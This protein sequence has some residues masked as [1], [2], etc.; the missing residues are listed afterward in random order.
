MNNRSY[1]CDMRRKVDR[2]QIIEKGLELMYSNGYE[3]TGIKEIADASGI[4]KGSFYNYFASKE[5][6]AKALIER[7]SEQNY[8]FA[9]SFLCDQS[10]SPVKRMELLFDAI[11]KS[12]ATDCGYSKGCFLGN[13]SQ[14]IGD[15]NPYLSKVVNQSM[16]SIKRLYVDCLKEAQSVGEIDKDQDPEMLAEFIINSWQGVLLRAKSAKNDD[17]FVSFKGQVFNRLLK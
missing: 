10:I 9:Q 16:S 4:L 11:W 15:S 1:I 7:Y 12:I 2:E 5:E 17:A 14:E 6:F 13:C 3:A 8:A